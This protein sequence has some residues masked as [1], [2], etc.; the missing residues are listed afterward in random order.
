MID[1]EVI[2]DTANKTYS[3][4]TLDHKTCIEYGSAEKIDAFLFDH[5]NEYREVK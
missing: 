4:M 1:V 5:S 2:Y 3:I